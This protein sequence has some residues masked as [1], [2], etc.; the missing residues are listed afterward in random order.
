MRYPMRSIMAGVLSVCAL[1]LGAGGGAAPQAREPGVAHRAKV[2]SPNFVSVTGGPPPIAETL[3]GEVG[4]SGA[5]LLTGTQVGPTSGEAG[6][7]SIPDKG[8]VLVCPG[9]VDI[10]WDPDELRDYENGQPCP[11][12][13]WWA[14][15][16]GPSSDPATW[17]IIAYGPG[18]WGDG[19]YRDETV[20]SGNT[21][22]YG[23]ITRFDC[24][25][26]GLHQV[27]WHFSPP[28]VV[29]DECSGHV[30]RD[31]TLSGAQ[32]I[33]VLKVWEG[34]TLTLSSVTM[35]DGIIG[36]AGHDGVTDPPG[37][38][39]QVFN[40]TLHG[41]V[42]SFAAKGANQVTGSTLSSYGAGYKVVE[43]TH[44][45]EVLISGNKVMSAWIDIRGAPDVTVV[46]NAFDEGA[47]YGSHETSL[48]PDKIQIAYNE[49]RGASRIHQ[50]CGGATVMGNE[51]LGDGSYYA[52]MADCFP[53]KE[54]VEMHIVGNHIVNCNPGIFLDEY[55]IGTLED[56]RIVESQYGVK[57]RENAQATIEG[58][59]FMENGYGVQ[60]DDEASATLRDNC[61]AGNAY[62]GVSYWPGFAGTAD[63]RQNWWG[64][65]S[66]PLHYGTNPDGQGDYAWSDV[67]IDNWLERDNCFVDATV[68][69]VDGEGGTVS[70]RSGR[71]SIWLSPGAV[72]MK[73]QVSL[74]V[75]DPSV[76]ATL[77]QAPQGLTGGRVFH[78]S[79]KGE[80][81]G[82][83]V[84]QLEEEARLSVAL[85]EEEVN[86]V[87]PGTVSVW[88][89]SGGPLGGRGMAADLEGVLVDEETWV[90][91][92]TDVGPE[93]ETLTATTEYLGTFA[94][95]GES[96]V[97]CVY[98][99]LVTKES[100]ADGV[101][102][103]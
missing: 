31:L 99:P 64:H 62:A 72:I 75:Q 52:I 9:L 7:A 95:L 94:V 20:Q 4:T 23:L 22:Y 65:P 45:A 19:F 43:V 30:G 81:S 57:M 35:E 69:T 90:P 74:K 56:N 25:V 70:S 39:I 6:G 53:E 13:D 101:A 87:E 38:V 58:N 15:D 16:R 79:A 96:T 55:A 97:R 80:T 71:T 10:A 32:T 50:V 63:A 66:G 91:L 5:R 40:S 27:T 83:P 12:R 60:L 100:P 68:A 51:F 33:G 48:D 84:T 41:T 11:R 24:P 29:T 98:L 37:G 17:E 92:P 59:C 78:V 77:P 47:V 82:V 44:D 34:A 3:Y 67:L 18:P 88:H 46:G 89:M 54:A 21:Y 49:F 85:T 86:Q 73:T 36:S 42:V 8:I 102:A 26:G 103:R 2:V 14:V 76:M 61:I 93:G 28:A 1:L